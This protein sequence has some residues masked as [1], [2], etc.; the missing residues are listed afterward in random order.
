MNPPANGNQIQ[1]IN[2]GTL[3]TGN[4]TQS[5]ENSSHT[6]FEYIYQRL[7]KTLRSA[8]L[9]V[10]KK[11]SFSHSLED[12]KAEV[13]SESPNNETISKRLDKLMSIATIVSGTSALV[14]IVDELAELLL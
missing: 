4:I 1:I 7:K 11:H 3:T 10:D 9:S 13:Q 5:S 8:D 6:D 12:I 14:T 2:H